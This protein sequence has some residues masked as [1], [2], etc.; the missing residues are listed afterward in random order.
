[1]TVKPMTSCPSKMPCLELVALQ[2]FP[3]AGTGETTPTTDLASTNE[4]LRDVT[5]ASLMSSVLVAAVDGMHKT[6]WAVWTTSSWLCRALLLWLMGLV[7]AT[8]TVIARP[9]FTSMF[10]ESIPSG[11]TNYSM[12]LTEMILYRMSYGQ[13]APGRPQSRSFGGRFSFEELMGAMSTVT[14]TILDPASQNYSQPVAMFAHPP[15]PGCTPGPPLGG[16]S[17]SLM[18]WASG[19][20]GWGMRHMEFGGSGMFALRQR[21]GQVLSLCGRS[22]GFTRC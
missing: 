17:R 7:V 12:E 11:V 21:R 10:F 6:R 18:S 3:V 4:A 2:K 20:V 19:V 22:C 14:P 13:H 15:G 9:A 16:P 1:M 8:V 5:S